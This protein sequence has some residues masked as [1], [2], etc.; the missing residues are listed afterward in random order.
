[1]VCAFGLWLRFLNAHTDLSSPSVDENDVVQQAVA[2]MGGEWRY[3]LLE[4]G[5]LPMYLLAAVYHLVAQ[6]RGLTPLEYAARVFYDGGEQYLIA[7]LAC[8]AG[9]A[10]LALVSYR[11]LAPR[12]GRSAGV[13]SAVLLALPTVDALTDGTV[14]IDVLQ[15]AF[16]LGAVLALTLTLE[17]RSTRYWLIAG[18]CAGLGIASKPMPGLLVAPCFLVASWFATAEAGDGPSSPSAAPS[19]TPKPKLQALAR[20]ALRTLLRP[21]MWWSA[22]ATL[23]AAGLGNPTSLNLPKFVAAQRDAMAYYSGASAPGTHRGVFNSLLPLGT[24]FLV[25]AA[26]SVAAMPFV[27]DARAR[28]IALFPLV[29]VTAFWGRPMR[30]YYLVAPSMALCVVIGIAVGLLLCRMGLDA[31]APIGTTQSTEARSSRAWA[32]GWLG[33]VLPLALSGCAAYAVVAKLD[34][35]RRTLSSGTLARAWIHQN[36]PPLTGIFQ[37]GTVAGG[38]RLVAANWKKEMELADFFDY[39]RENYDFYHRAYRKAFKDYVSQGRPYYALEAVRLAPAPV[40]SPSNPP[41]WLQRGLL[42]RANKAGQ[43]YIILGSFKGTDDDFSKLGYSWL[44][45]VK[46]AQQFARIA[47]FQVPKPPAPPTEGPAPTP[48]GAAPA[49][50][51]ATAAPD[52]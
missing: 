14:R 6:L 41:G 22:L 37:Y 35:A 27:R 30:R 49:T 3:Y 38:A 2:F 17:S 46:L 18:V 45:K 48:A 36:I 16:Q 8:A 33:L 25:V 23:V 7:R 1:M 34:L 42:G 39:G 28:L 21:G 50:P 15:G 12:F 20:R 11:W 13:T 44:P 4:Y 5:P 26:L 31:P 52:G 29:Y 47:I 40:Q 32:R 24:P 43:E 9:Y 51:A 10:L 19:V